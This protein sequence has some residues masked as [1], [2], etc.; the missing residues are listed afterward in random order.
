MEAHRGEQGEEKGRER[1]R[2]LLDSKRINNR[3]WS[4]VSDVVVETVC[5]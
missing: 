2:L 3:N 5:L 1:G 4:M